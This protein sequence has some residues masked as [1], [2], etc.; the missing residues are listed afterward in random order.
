[1]SEIL[2]VEV[3]NKTNDLKAVRSILENLGAQFKG[4]DHQVDTYFYTDTGRLKLRE[5]NIEKSLIHYERA[6]A[7]GI[8]DSSINLL[9]LSETDE[10]KKILIKS[11][12]IKVVVDKR[13][14]IF[15]I[16]NVKFHL[17][18]VEGLGTFVEIEAIDEFGEKSKT[19]LDTQCKKYFELLKLEESN[20]ISFSYS[21]MIIELTSELE[22]L[23]NE[24]LK[25]FERDLSSGIEKNSLNL[26]YYY[27]DH[28][29][30]RTKTLDEYLN[31]KQKLNLLGN[32]LIS[33]QIG[34]RE[35]TTYKLRKPLSILGQNVYVLEL[36]APKAGSKY[37]TGFEHV[38]YVIDKSFDDFAQRYPWIEFD[39]S[40]AS[41]EHN[42]ELRVK[43][44]KN[45]SIKFHHDN[46]E[47]I[48]KKELSN[49]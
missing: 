4:I 8:K 14:E 18:I 46:L 16:E 40:G 21:D 5:G 27:I 12:G 33:S 48:I 13:R 23:L 15:F 42:P 1:M 34:G 41:K 6:N 44:D 45:V 30:F 19:E 20:N 47:N 31:I 36:P 24:G 37:S 32:V 29:C 2:N 38:E 39:W 11:N 26:K 43:F 3:K 7:N 35:I 25:S 10:L 49:L 22:S 9:R 28:I 17:D